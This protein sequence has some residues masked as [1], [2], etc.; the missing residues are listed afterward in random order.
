VAVPPFKAGDFFNYLNGK[1]GYSDYYEI[2]TYQFTVTTKF[3]DG[4]TTVT[5]GGTKTTAR[6]WG[7]GGDAGSGGPS[8]NGAAGAAGQGPPSE[9]SGQAGWDYNYYDLTL[10]FVTLRY[11][12]ATT[13]RGYLGVGPGFYKGA[14]LPVPV[15]FGAGEGRFLRL[16][17]T[18][19]DK[20]YAKDLDD[21]L[22][23]LSVAWSA[24][25]LL[26]S[27]GH[28][29]SLSNDSPFFVTDVAFE[30]GAAAGLLGVGGSIS[31]SIALPGGW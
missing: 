22:K 5:D 15:G 7:G 4:T 14:Q 16:D 2:V 26:G 17:Q 30:R 3:S 20:D 25:L 11:A 19:R 27:T 9:R 24:V 10:W 8:G 12:R 13:G 28:S 6:R 31:Y 29:V 1:N 21:R 23:G 18:G